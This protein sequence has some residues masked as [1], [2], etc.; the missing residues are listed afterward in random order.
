MSSSSTGLCAPTTVA[1]Q[2]KVKGYVFYDTSLRLYYLK[3]HKGYVYAKECAHVYSCKEARAEAA[4]VPG[5]GGKE[6]GKW[7]VVYE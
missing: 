7:I 2:R 1:V 6:E 5:W 3:P 4:L